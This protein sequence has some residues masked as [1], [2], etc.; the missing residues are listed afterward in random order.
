MVSVLDCGSSSPGSIPCRGQCV[1]V[2]SKTPYSPPRSINRYRRIC[3]NNLTESRGV[4]CYFSFLHFSLSTSFSL[5][6]FVNNIVFMSSSGEIKNTNT[7]TNTKSHPRRGAIL[8][9][10]LCYR[11]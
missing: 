1:V 3:W 10:E 2:L 5:H 6:L 8:L 4:T 11:N 7:N 9:A